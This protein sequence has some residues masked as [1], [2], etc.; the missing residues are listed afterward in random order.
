MGPCGL[1]VR[2]V[3][4]LGIVVAAGRAATA[5]GVAVVVVLA[6]ELA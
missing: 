6:K 4:A 5:A 1:P 3:V 2:G